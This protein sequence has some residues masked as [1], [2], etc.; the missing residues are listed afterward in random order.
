[1]SELPL[2]SPSIPGGAA[3]ARPAAIQ[4]S[5]HQQAGSIRHGDQLVSWGPHS[6][7]V[8]F[9]GSGG[10]CWVGRALGRDLRALRT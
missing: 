8:G 10:D 3:Q 2:L 9:R 7:W 5:V 4:H 6:T 1:M